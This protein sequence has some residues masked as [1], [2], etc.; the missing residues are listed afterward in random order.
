MEDG[1]EK[2]NVL[3]NGKAK[4]SVRAFVE[5]PFHQLKNIFKHRKTRY[6][7]LDKNHHQLQVLFGLGNL[8]FASR[9]MS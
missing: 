1:D 6:R 4:A 7:G 2:G 3:A 9:R 8:V 5:H